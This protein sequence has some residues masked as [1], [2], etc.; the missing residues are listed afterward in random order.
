MRKFTSEDCDRIDRET[1]LYQKIVVYA[2]ENLE[3]PSAGQM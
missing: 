2:A 1:D 3:E